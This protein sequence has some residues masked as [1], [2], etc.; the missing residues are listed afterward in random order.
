MMQ[1]YATKLELLWDCM[2]PAMGCCAFVP[3]I[4]GH[5]LWPQQSCSIVISELL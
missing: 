1:H 3:V 4:T 5:D 2:Q